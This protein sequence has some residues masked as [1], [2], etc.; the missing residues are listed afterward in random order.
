MVTAVLTATAV[1]VIVN[2]GEVV[3]PAGTVTE[4]GT[5]V[6]GSLLV[7]IT[8]A[9]PDGAAP[10]SV[11]VFPLVDAP[12]TTEVGDSVTAETV[13][14]AGRTVKVAVFVTLLYVAEMVTAVLTATRSV[15]RG[16]GGECVAPG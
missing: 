15:E 2:V 6:L 14:L 9:P 10:V 8:S 16:V 7:S 13:G 1:V 4:A 11:T 5:V 3:A 12:P